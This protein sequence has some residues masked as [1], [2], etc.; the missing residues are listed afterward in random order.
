M[1]IK[2]I[3]LFLKPR[4][5]YIAREACYNDIQLKGLMTITNN[6]FFLLIQCLEIRLTATW[7]TE[8]AVETPDHLDLQM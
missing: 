2:L 1:M 6:P 8:T 4:D 7:E 5:W 3:Y